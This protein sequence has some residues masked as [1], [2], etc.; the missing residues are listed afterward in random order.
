VE[1]F[2]STDPVSLNSK[3][4]R[5]IAVLFPSADFIGISKYSFGGSTVLLVSV[6][7]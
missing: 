4:R 3:G 2:S 5:K 1:L 6:A 7:V